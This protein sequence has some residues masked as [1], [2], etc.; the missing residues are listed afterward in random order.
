MARV[1]EYELEYYS[2][3]VSRTVE[4][5]DAVFDMQCGILYKF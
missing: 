5:S 2:G 4:E 1:Y 3:H